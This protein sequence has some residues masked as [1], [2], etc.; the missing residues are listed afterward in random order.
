MR[1]ALQE[2]GSALELIS[3][4]IH[5]ELHDDTDRDRIAMRDTESR[6]LLDAV[7]EVVT[8]SQDSARAIFV[9]FDIELKAYAF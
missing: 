1:Q 4:R 5:L 9:F 7:R 3:L 6:V 2:L 8:A